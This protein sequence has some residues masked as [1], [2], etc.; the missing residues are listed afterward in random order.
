MSL[1]AAGLVAL[2]VAAWKT[3]PRRHGSAPAYLDGP[4]AMAGSASCRSCHEAFYE[5]WSASFHGLAM[6]P[7][8]RVFARDHLRPPAASIVV[9]GRSYRAVIGTADD[10]VEETGP[11]GRHRRTRS[12]RSWAARTSSTS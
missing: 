11:D 10:H 5:Q 2:G 12:P 6:R 3:L 1:A 4:A 8:T 9:R 7:Y